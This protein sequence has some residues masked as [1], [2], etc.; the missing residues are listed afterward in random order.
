M[1]FSRRGRLRLNIIAG[2]N[3]TSLID[4]VFTLLM[5]L[6]L[7]SSFQNETGID[8]ALPAAE[9]AAESANENVYTVSINTGGKVFAGRSE[10]RVEQLG[11]DVAAWLQEHAGGQIVVKSDAK[12]EVQALVSV[13][14]ELRKAKAVNVSLAAQPPAVSER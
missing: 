4:L 11:N 12:V 7:T 8:V 13:M 2:V 9:T 1:E 10:V 6:L 14:D 3:I 5:F